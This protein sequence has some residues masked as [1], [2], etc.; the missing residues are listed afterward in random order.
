LQRYFFLQKGSMYYFDDP[1]KDKAL[2]FFDLRGCAVMDAEEE[3]KK[4]PPAHT[5]SLVRLLR[6]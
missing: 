1:S 4:Y 6:N 5:P 3:T 2:G